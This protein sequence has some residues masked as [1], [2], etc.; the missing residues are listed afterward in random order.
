MSDAKL[1]FQAIDHALAAEVCRWHTSDDALL[2]DTVLATSFALQ[3][4]HSCLLLP[5]AAEELPARPNGQSWPDASVWQAQ[6]AQ[7]PL[8]EAA[9]SPII[10]E[11]HRVYLRRYWRFEQE[12]AQFVQRHNQTTP[13]LDAQQLKQAKSLLSHYFEASSG[14]TNWQQLAAANTLLSQFSVI[15]GGPGTGKTYTVTRILAL[16]ASL[17]PDSPPIIKLAAPTGKAAQRLAE[18][19]LQAKQS[20]HLDMLIADAVPNEASTLHRLL[21]VIPNQLQFRH[22]QDNPIDA[23]ILLV[24]EVSMIDLPLM[25]RLLRAIK[26]HTRLIFLGDA[27]QLPSVAA[28]SV[29][30][31]LSESPHPGYSSRRLTELKKL[32]IDSTDL[33]QAQNNTHANDYLTTL[34]VSRRFKDSSG[35]G[36]LARAILAGQ[37][38]RADALFGEYDDISWQ[39][40]D[41]LAPHLNQWADTYYRPIQRSETLAEAFERL[42]AFRILVA[43]REGDRGVVAIN[44]HIE[45]RLNSQRQRFFKGQ[46]IMVTQNHYGLRLFNGDIGLLWPNDNGILMAWFEGSEG[47]RAVAPGRLPAI[48]TVY[49]MTIHKTQ[50][51]EFNRVAMVLPDYPTPLLTRELIYTGLTRA[52]KAFDCVGQKDIWKRG[53]EKR[54]SRW[55]GLAEALRF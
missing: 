21:G 12:V 3:Q 47:P 40:G 20:L 2:Y 42:K 48:E 4:G 50:G 16:L 39:L 25:A 44:A 55:A 53:I 1:T 24:D 7:W 6:L 18:A 33:P 37:S 30:A 51:S 13:T 14:T 46:P 8:T 10:A 29:L 27:N 19:I 17:T 43:Q 15:V 9:Q 52:K 5:S 38:A 32:G 35:I 41:P 26:P 36:Q 54:V 22:H 23:D 31:D 45:Q 49:A 11:R 34:L 28:G